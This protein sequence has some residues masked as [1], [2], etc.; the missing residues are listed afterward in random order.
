M[1]FLMLCEDFWTYWTHRAFHTPLMYNMIHKKHHAY[2]STVAWAA[3]YTHPFELIF[4]NALPIFSGVLFLG[5][6]I[7]TIGYSFFI[8]W[9]ITKTAESH[10][11]YNNK[12]SFYNLLPFSA[13]PD[14]HN[15]HHYRFKGNYGSFFTF[16]DFMGGTFNKAYI[17]DKIYAYKRQG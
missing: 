2:K 3:E 7:T 13:N 17:N 15:Y 6:D 12:V 8:W 4:G 10:S 16:W 1:L 14:N 11:G 5:K 9:R